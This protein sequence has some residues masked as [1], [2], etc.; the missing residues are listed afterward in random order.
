[1]YYRVHSNISICYLITSQKTVMQALSIT[2]CPVEL[3]LLA[4]LVKVKKILAK[5][6]SHAC[7]KT[8]VSHVRAGM[9]C[10]RKTTMMIIIIQHT[11]KIFVIKIIYILSQF[12]FS[13]NT[14]SIITYISNTQYTLNSGVIEIQNKYVTIKGFPQSK[15]IFMTIKWLM[16]SRVIINRTYW[17][18]I[19]RL[20]STISLKWVIT[21]EDLTINI[22]FFYWIITVYI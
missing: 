22:N 3:Y 16:F 4:V 13:Y 2:N 8:C 10:G 7:M 6:P 17:I 12:T 20:I 21:A 14:I 1:M 18:K 11:S 15:Y 9:V 19:I 5:Y